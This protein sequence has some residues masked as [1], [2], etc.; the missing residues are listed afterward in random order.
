MTRRASALF[1]E[2]GILLLLIKHQTN[3]INTGITRYERFVID[4][5][6]SICYN[7]ALAKRGSG[8]VARI[9]PR[10]LELHWSRS[11]SAG[12]LLFHVVGDVFVDCRFWQGDVEA[13]EPEFP[14]DL[15]N[16]LNGHEAGV[17]HLNPLFGNKSCG[18]ARA[19]AWLC[20]SFCLVL[21]LLVGVPF[22][23]HRRRDFDKGGW[24][25]LT[26]HKKDGRMLCT[27]SNMILFS[28][29]GRLLARKMLSGEVH[30]VA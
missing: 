11:S 13:T 22:C 23:S 5:Q 1:L 25:G 15:F 3:L 10:Q 21:W 14:L 19:S 6:W 7:Y 2:W 8:W 30:H 17:F 12:G 29:R 28:F 20:T 24:V 4:V 9:H 26:R 27:R 18:V 16:H